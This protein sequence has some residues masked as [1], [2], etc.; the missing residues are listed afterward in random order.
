VR[1][2][3]WQKIS[4]ERDGI[5][6]EGFMVYTDKIHLVAD[7]IEE[8]HH[9]AA[10]IGLRREQFQSHPRHPHYDLRGSQLESALKNGAVV[11]GSKEIVRM[12]HKL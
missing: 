4:P 1:I 2:E 5:N 6:E 11:V 10:K 12:S 9:F 7:H 8:L 3:S